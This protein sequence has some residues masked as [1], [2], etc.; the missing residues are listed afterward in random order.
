MFRDLNAN[1]LVI[2]LSLIFT[3]L[4]FILIFLA[5][6]EA[7]QDHRLIKKRLKGNWSD[8]NTGTIL[9]TNKAFD[10]FANHL[11]LP[12]EEEI[13]K[14]RARLARAGFYGTSSVKY[15]Y[16]IR[17][18]A[19]VVPLLIFLTSWGFFQ[20]QLEPARIALIC[21]GLI[22][23]GLM[24]P[25]FFVGWRENAQT[26]VNRNG[27]P[28]MMDLLV[29]CIEAGLGMNAAL[30]RVADE[31]G[32]RYP[33]LKIN[34]DLLNLELRAGRER[35]QGMMNFANRVNLEE[36][37]ALAVMIRQS[38]EMGSSLG[39]S[40]RSFSDEMRNKRKMRAEEKAMALPA[41]MTV[42]LIL[43]IFPA[44][45]AMLMTPAAIRVMEGLSL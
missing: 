4:A 42:P 35:N 27:F 40:L 1:N 5:V 22:L 14:I 31:I 25:T 45:I 11:T 29:A 41:K 28:D 18:L 12:D 32:G 15:Y 39:K 2:S 19:I 17:I 6:R 34:L 13:S 3:I 36:A 9:R 8:K 33:P 43:F 38:E 10:N 20:I 16:A 37:K 44:I 30:L 7:W 23:G 26:Q 21:V 24:A